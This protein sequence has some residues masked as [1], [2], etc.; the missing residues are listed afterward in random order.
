MNVCIAKL[1]RAA[2]VASLLVAVA[3]TVPWTAVA[4]Q[5]GDEPAGI[6]P[7]TGEPPGAAKGCCCIPK[8][9]PTAG[10]EFDCKSGVTHFDCKAECAGLKDGRKPSGCKW[11]EGACKP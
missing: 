1:G 8:L 3:A 10:N 5:N 2:L 9:H 6:S 4:A 11:D 7:K